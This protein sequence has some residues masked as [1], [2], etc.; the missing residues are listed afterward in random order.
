MQSSENPRYKTT[1]IR[2]TVKYPY[3][4]PIC[5]S[6]GILQQSLGAGEPSR[7]RVVTLARQQST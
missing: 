3:P 2:Q 5:A 4:T 7:K 1:K 6:A